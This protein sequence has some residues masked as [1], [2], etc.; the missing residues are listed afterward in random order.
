MYL[1]VPHVTW[2]IVKSNKKLVHLAIKENY[3]SMGI[4]RIVKV[5]IQPEELILGN[6]LRII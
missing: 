5:K 1:Y 4:R 3:T 2:S 6:R